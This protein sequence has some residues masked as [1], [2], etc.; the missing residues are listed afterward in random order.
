MELVQ[1]VF[2][3]YKLCLHSECLLIK[4]Y[5]QALLNVNKVYVDRDVIFFCN[6]AILLRALV[7]R[8]LNRYNSALYPL[9][10]FLFISQNKLYWYQNFL[11]M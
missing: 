6:T 4:L 10:L 5:S 11:M 8:H 2:C 7:K 1:L 9:S 3:W